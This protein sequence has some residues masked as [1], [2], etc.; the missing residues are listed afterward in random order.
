MRT[1]RTKLVL[2]NS[3]AS[4]LGNTSVLHSV[5]IAQAINENICIFNEYITISHDIV[6]LEL[7]KI[8]EY[9]A[10]IFRS[11]VLITKRLQ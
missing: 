6:D 1:G 3:D 5:G 4:L 11:T 8:D 7:K 10:C 2:D 9:S